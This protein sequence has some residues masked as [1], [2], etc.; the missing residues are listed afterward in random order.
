MDR[1]FPPERLLTAAELSPGVSRNSVFGY[2]VCFE[3]PLGWDWS[4]T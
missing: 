4:P 3:V 2:C 1:G